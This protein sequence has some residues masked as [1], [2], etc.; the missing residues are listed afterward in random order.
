MADKTPNYLSWD[1]PFE[2]LKE[3]KTPSPGLQS[4]YKR[5]ASLMGLMDYFYDFELKASLAGKHP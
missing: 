1:P 2:Q 4:L 3:T 5:Y